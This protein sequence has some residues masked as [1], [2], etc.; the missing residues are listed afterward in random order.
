MNL[1]QEKE[2]R[3]GQ[4]VFELLLDP[5]GCGLRSQSRRW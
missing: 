1:L 3:V 2:L 4:K 5:P